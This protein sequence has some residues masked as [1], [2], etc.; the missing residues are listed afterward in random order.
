MTEKEPI[1]AEAVKKS[2]AGLW[3]AIGCA[4]V[5]GFVVLIAGGIMLLAVT[6][7]T[8]MRFEGMASLEPPKHVVENPPEIA[9]AGTWLNTDQPLTLADLR[10]NVVWL[11]F[12]FLH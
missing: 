2:S 5:F 8:T 9:S 10:G 1:P 6:L 3:L 11:E 12:S 4:A 7:W